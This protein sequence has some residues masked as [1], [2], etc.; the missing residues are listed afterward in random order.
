MANLPLGHISEL[1]TLHDKG[2]HGHG[3]LFQLLPEVD[4]IRFIEY[5]NP[6]AS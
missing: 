3:H 1:R 6:Q 2:R 5:F 4:G